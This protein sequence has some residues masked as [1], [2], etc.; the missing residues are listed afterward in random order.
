MEWSIADSSPRYSVKLSDT[1]GTL[2]LTDL[3]SDGNEQPIP[4]ISIRRDEQ[5]GR[6]LV[7]V[8]GSARFAHA[9]GVGDS[10][11]IHMNGR[12]HVLHGHQPGSASADVDEGS[13]SALMPGTIL[14]VLVKEGQ[15][16]REGQTLLVMEA[17]K[18]EHRILAPKA[19]E[20]LAVNFAAGDRV[21]MG[22][23]LVELGD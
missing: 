1:D 2:T 17:M 22:A 21:D 3:Q 23:T 15:R 20:V 11:W 13:L 10:W 19:G 12:I 16:V 14:E 6:L 5:A 4:N 18:M 9:R 8:D 7:E